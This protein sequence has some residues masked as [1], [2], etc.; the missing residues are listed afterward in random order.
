MNMIFAVAVG[1][2]LGAVSRYLMMIG[3]GSWLGHGFPYG[4]LIVNVIGSF[5]LGSL[6]ET[7]ALVWSPAPEVR[8][9]IV[10]GLLGAFTTFS[11]FSLDAVILAQR[12]EYGLAGLYILGSVAFGIIGF[13]GG[14]MVFRQVLS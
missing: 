8:T 5:M 3:I 7:M 11:T 9:F 1:G 13:M 10:V 2:A 12:G 14:M 4:T 6:M